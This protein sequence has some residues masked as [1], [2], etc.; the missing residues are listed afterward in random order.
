MGRGHRSAL[1]AAIASLLAP[2][3][4]VGPAAAAPAGAGSDPAQVFSVSGDPGAL[5]EEAVEQR[6]IIGWE[7][8]VDPATRAAVVR[9]E[10]WDL[11][12]SFDALD[13]SVVSDVAAPA[14]AA[15]DLEASPLVRF[16]ES[17]RL[18]RMFG[19][20]DEPDFGKLWGLHN[21]G[22]TDLAGRVGI[23]DADIDAPEAWASTMGEESVVVAVI[24]DGLDLDHPAFAGRVF[25]NSGE[26]QGDGVDNDLNG[27]VDDVHGWDFVDDDAD[28]NPVH[29]AH[30]T[31]VAGTVAA[32]FDGADVVGVAPGVTI[33]PLRVCFVFCTLS[34]QI[35]AINYA[36][37]MG[38]DVA[39]LSLGGPIPSSAMDRAMHTARDLVFAIAAGNFGMNSDRFPMYPC[40]APIDRIVCVAASTN[41]DQLAR[42]SNRGRKGVDVAAPGASIL[43]TLPADVSGDLLEEG[44]EGPFSWTPSGGIAPAWG[45]T[46]VKPRAGDVALADSPAGP[47][48]NRQRSLI[49]SP[50]MT[51]PAD[52]SCSWQSWVKM[53]IEPDFDVLDAFVV[54]DGVRT[55]LAT[56]SGVQP[57]YESLKLDL[58]AYRGE[59]IRLGYRFISDR[60]VTS[61]G[62][63]IDDV[64]V[65]CADG[66]AV[67]RVGAFDGTSMAAPHVAGVLALMRSACPACTPLQLREALVGSVDPVAAFQPVL[68]SGGRV[69]AAA[70]VAAVIDAEPAAAITSV[71]PAT[72]PA[73]SV[74]SLEI[75]GARFGAPSGLSLGGGIDVLGVQRI[76]DT[77]LRADVIV[78]DDA[79]ASEQTLT[80]RFGADVPASCGDC[81][82]V[83]AAVPVPVC[84]GVG[85]RVAV[86][87]TPVRDT[88]TGTDA[89][90]V[91]CGFGGDDTI[92][93]AGGD[94]IV[95]GGFGHD[96]LRGGA[97]TDSITGGPG[98]DRL[99]GESGADVLRAR[100]QQ[101]DLVRG[102]S[103]PSGTADLCSRDRTDDVSGCEILR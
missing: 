36:A 39:N 20:V 95:V 79:S 14:G 100:F 56:I 102:G 34:G 103:Q 7:P 92:A 59:S 71:S 19:V 12:V 21:T 74:A 58:S 17:D 47:Y 94:D 26:V 27:Y 38:A 86:P 90:E 55:V 91:F 29:G 32:G 33:L 64:A 22:Q 87:G 2:V 30:G 60:Y 84:E 45:P 15:E 67:G 81:F 96:V 52:A 5:S 63:V 98:R 9:S 83:T 49:T 68:A 77:V 57:T 62:V 72:L 43:S 78:P 10:G 53:S 11:D 85:G 99:F 44:F 28:A 18:D 51:L 70:A 73:G 4:V 37:A 1:I 3:L 101:S 65:R 16:A 35:A 50:S 25:T 24:D 97:G 88:L 89:A 66:G 76:S 41:Q 46:T 61:S 23:A 54:A 80:V 40:Q 82:A 48:P 8:G 93:A 31:H 42:F 6:L 13:L 75:T 69:N